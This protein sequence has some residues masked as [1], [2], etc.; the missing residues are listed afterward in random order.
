MNVSAQAS[1]LKEPLLCSI[2]ASAHIRLVKGVIRRN[3]PITVLCPIL[4]N[5]I[6]CSRGTGPVMRGK[7]FRPKLLVKNYGNPNI[8]LWSC[9]GCKDIF[10]KVNLTEPSST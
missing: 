4:A 5:G 9:E 6:I 2:E 7:P 1:F 8:Q 3:N 10:L